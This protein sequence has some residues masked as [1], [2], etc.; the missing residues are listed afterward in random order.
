VPTH[1]QI[2]QEKAKMAALEK[3]KRKNISLSPLSLLNPR[4]KEDLPSD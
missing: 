1:A 2:C 3:W 4:K